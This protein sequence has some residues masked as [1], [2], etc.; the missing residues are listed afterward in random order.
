[1]LFENVVY[2][3]SPIGRGK[4]NR[5]GGMRSCTLHVHTKKLAQLGGTKCARV[6]VK[7]C[8]DGNTST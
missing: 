1:M 6:Q 4:A 2:T 7:W 3:L 5:N 8:R